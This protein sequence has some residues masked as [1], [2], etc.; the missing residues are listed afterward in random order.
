MYIKETILSRIHTQKLTHDHRTFQLKWDNGRN[1]FLE[2]WS[3]TTDEHGNVYK[4]LA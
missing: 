3:H 1:F 4:E 2:P